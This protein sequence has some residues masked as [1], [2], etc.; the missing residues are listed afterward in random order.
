MY[1]IPYLT[2]QV[3]PFSALSSTSGMVSQEHEEGE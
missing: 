3:N 1:I 2:T